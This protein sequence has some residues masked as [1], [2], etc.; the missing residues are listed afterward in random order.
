MA[1]YA[2]VRPFCS[3][4]IGGPTVF[5]TIGDSQLRG[6]EPS[7]ASFI[8]RGG[9]KPYAFA[10]MTSAGQNPDFQ[11]QILNSTD[12]V[13]TCGT[14]HGGVEGATSANWVG[15]YYATWKAALTA[16]PHIVAI[17]L[18]ANDA[19]SAAAAASI[20]T[21][22]DTVA[23]D[24]PLAS[25]LVST[26]PKATAVPNF[27]SLHRAQVISDVAARRAN[28]MHVTL[29][30]QWPVVDLRNMPDLLHCDKVGYRLLGDLWSGYLI[31]LANGL[32]AA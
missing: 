29:V 22:T 10:A 24:Y 4:P 11:G 31:A 18:G 27:G 15:T 19:D 13:T 23:A 28:G 12:G 5:A 16:T 32:A 2:Y 6:A 1:Q 8:R 7:A 30:D 3:A 9:W 26:R 20:A 25:I 17:S 21:L 14:S